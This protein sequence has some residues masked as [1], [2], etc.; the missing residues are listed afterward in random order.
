MKYVIWNKNCTQYKV[1][2]IQASSLIYLQYYNILQHTNKTCSYITKQ[3][4]KKANK[5]RFRK[6]YLPSHVHR[7]ELRL[8]LVCTTGQNKQIK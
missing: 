4:K 5:K 2:K 7:G 3:N 1:L 6:Q 8:C